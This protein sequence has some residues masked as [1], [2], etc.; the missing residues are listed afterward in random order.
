[1]IHIAGQ[2][3]LNILEEIVIKWQFKF[4]K[5]SALLVCPWRSNCLGET[6]EIIKSTSGVK[7]QDFKKFFSR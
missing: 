5:F 2:Q 3:M 1:M 4:V 6:A 7:G